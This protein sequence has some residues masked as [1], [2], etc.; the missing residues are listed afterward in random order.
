MLS[1]LYFSIAYVIIGMLVAMFDNWIEGRFDE[2]GSYLPK[3]SE[4]QNVSMTFLWPLL[5]LLMVCMVPLLLMGK[6]LKLKDSKKGAMNFI[7][8][9]KVREKPQVTYNQEDFNRFVE[10]RL[11]SN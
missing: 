8:E 7:R 10:K 2:D 11:K 3:L 1:A 9:L 6:L 4:P 5:I